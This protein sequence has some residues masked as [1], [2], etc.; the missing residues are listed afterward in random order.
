MAERGYAGLAFDYRCFG[1]SEGA[2]RQFENPDANIADIR[3][4]A[5]ALLANSRLSNLPVFGL[6]VCF[7]AG[8]M[9]RAV[10]GDQRFGGSVFHRPAGAEPGHRPLRARAGRATVR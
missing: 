9:V 2:P 6:G 3:N 7:G 5:T 8:P 1:E 10:A 4:A